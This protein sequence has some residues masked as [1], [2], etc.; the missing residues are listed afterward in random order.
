MLLIHVIALLFATSPVS[1][2]FCYSTPVRTIC[3]PPELPLVEF[4]A[5]A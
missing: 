1:T 2:G 4:D 3:V 5:G